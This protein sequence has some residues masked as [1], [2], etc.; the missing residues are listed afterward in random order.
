MCEYDQNT[1]QEKLYLKKKANQAQRPLLPRPHPNAFNA[2]LGW[3]SL[4]YLLPESLG[5]SEGP[6]VVGAR[7][8][9][10]GG[11]ASLAC[12]KLGTLASVTP[13][14]PFPFPASQTSP[15]K[16]EDGSGS[17]SSMG[18]GA[19]RFQVGFKQLQQPRVQLL[20]FVKNERALVAALLR[21]LHLPLQLLLHRTRGA[22][23]LEGEQ[24]PVS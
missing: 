4:F 12:Y 6:G 10:G 23:D 2:P 20:R 18:L 9:G 5:E 11:S 24:S 13:V 8:G 17:L 16:E 15:E 7:E 1:L 22:T 14:T 3:H 19:P 21:L